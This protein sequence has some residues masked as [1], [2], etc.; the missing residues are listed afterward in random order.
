MQQLELFDETLE[1]KIYRLERKLNWIHKEL[2]F[3][4]QVYHMRYGKKTIPIKPVQTDMFG[5]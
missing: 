5:T 1:N 4:K 2:C 3:L